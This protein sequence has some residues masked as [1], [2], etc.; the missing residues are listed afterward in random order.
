M[1]TNAMQSAHFLVK[2][3][4]VEVQGTTLITWST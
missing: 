3:A 1:S 2:A 4:Q